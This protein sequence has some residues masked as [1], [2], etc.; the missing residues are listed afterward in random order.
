MIGAL[1]ALFRTAIVTTTGIVITVGT[2]IV[3]IATTIGI[4][5]I[6][7]ITIITADLVTAAAD[8][9]GSRFA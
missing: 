8:N 9:R 3:F 5:T 2:G 7:A 1:Y 6:G 4:I